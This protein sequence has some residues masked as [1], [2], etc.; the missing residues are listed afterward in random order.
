MVR[1]LREEPDLSRMFM[2]FLLSRDIQI[3][4]DLIDHLFNS[5]EKRLA[6]ILLL[7]ANFGNV[8]LS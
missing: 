2:S 5:S 3:E 7:L 4:A 8:V 6:R 1:V